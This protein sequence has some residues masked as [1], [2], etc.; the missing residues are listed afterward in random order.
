MYKLQTYPQHWFFAFE[1][2]RVK[3]LFKLKCSNPFR[4]FEYKNFANPIAAIVPAVLVWG[5]ASITGPTSDSLTPTFA[6]R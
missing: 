6:W 3:E 4:F 2:M 1:A 5:F